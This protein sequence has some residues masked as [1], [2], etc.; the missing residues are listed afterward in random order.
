MVCAPPLLPWSS[1]SILHI[2][3]LSNIVGR[4]AA[5]STSF[6]FL[7]ELGS[8]SPEIGIKLMLSVH[9][10]PV[11][12]NSNDSFCVGDILYKMTIRFDGTSGS[13]SPKSSSFIENAACSSSSPLECALHFGR[14]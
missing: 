1:Y 8:T 4:T 6:M 10:R 5:F 11:L 2:I 13:T 3:S 12:K 7:C 9:K 14:S